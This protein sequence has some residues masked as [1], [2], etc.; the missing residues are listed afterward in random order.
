[1]SPFTS[2]NPKSGINFEDKTPEKS[3]NEDLFSNYITMKQKLMQNETKF[4]QND[5]TGM[6]L[7]SQNVKFR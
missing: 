6:I 2:I 4:M 5:L 1:M 7:I 3:K